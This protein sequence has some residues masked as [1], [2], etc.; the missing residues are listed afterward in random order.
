MLLAGMLTALGIFHMAQIQHRLEKILTVNNVQSRLTATMQVSVM[1]RMVALRNIVLVT[2]ASEL[3]QEIEHIRE[4]NRQYLSAEEQLEQMLAAPGEDGA[5]GKALL[6][7]IKEASSAALPLMTKAMELGQAQQTAEATRI[8]LAEVRPVQKQ[9]IAAL[10][11]MAK[12]VNKQSIMYGFDSANEYGKTRNLMLALAGIALLMGV[13]AAFLITR[14]LLRQLG[15]EP[16]HAVQLAERIAAGDLT[17]AIDTKAGDQSSML[18]ALREMRDS[19]ASLVGQVRNGT[20]AI[21][22]ASREIAA[23][24]MDLSSR[25]E[26]Q[27]SSLEQT[28]SSMEE[29]TSTVKQN[30][31]NARQANSLAL[32]ASDV[33]SQGGAV[34]SQVVDTMGSIN[35]SSKKI[36]DI[37][38]VIDGIAFQTNILALNAAVEAARAGEQGRG[39]AVVAAEV[40]TLAQRSAAAAKEI[41]ELI[42]DSVEKVDTGA[43]LVDQAGSTMQAIVDSIRRVTDIMGEISAASQEQTAGIEQINLAITQMDDV[44]QQNAALVEESAAAAQSMQSQADR[45]SQVVGVFKINGAASAGSG[46]RALANAKAAKPRSSAPALVSAPAKAVKPASP[47]ASAAARAPEPERKLALARAKDN[48]DWEEF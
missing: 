17:V 9:W 19:L 34:V 43:R 31:E 24:N 10:D 46:K 23:G 37:I 27:A 35:A 40:R 42:G 39:F 38:S 6:G 20:D 45:L 16:S 4:M 32:S 29:L 1:D 41:K 21:A 3:E 18:H 28:A 7:K 12:L 14:S 33:A 15:G 26:E 25:T 22:S 8:L 13:V 47:A 48:D 30:A 2:D 5:E 11:D 36:V 44:T